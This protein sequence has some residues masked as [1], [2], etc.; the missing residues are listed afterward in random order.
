[1][2]A[3]EKES[4]FP[5]E[6]TAEGVFLALDEG[7]RP[8]EGLA[9]LYIL[10]QKGIRAATDYLSRSLKAQLKFAHRNG[11]RYVL[12]WG[13][14]EKR[15]QKVKLRNMVRGEQLEL[16]PAEALNFLVENKV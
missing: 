8:E 5:G 9:L 13:Q 6:S 11:F 15:K 4:L 7:S 3:M 1:M 2:L 12:I 10:R 14:E 16:S